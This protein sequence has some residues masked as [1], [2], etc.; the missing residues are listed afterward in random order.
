MPKPHP[1]QGSNSLQ[2]CDIREGEEAAEEKSETCRGHWFI[3][4]KE[5]SHHH[6]RKEAATADVKDAASVSRRSSREEP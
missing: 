6:D 5:R 2:F 4:F 1:E 3:G